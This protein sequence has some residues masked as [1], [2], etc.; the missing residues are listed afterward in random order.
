MAKKKQSFEETLHE[1]N[2][3]IEKLEK[4]ELSLEDSMTEYKKG[5]ALLNDCQTMLIDAE[6]EFAQLLE[7]NKVEE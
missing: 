4:G 7:A 2:T 6:Q 3:I 1:A 5:F